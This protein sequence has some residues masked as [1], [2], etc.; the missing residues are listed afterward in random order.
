MVTA[1]PRVIAV[2]ALVLLIA[3]CT[4]P[5]G[6][7]T[8]GQGTQPGSTTSAAAKKRVAV[9]IRGNPTTLNAAINSAGPGGVAG[10]SEVEVMVHAGLGDVDLRRVVGPRLAERLPSV[11][12]GQWKLLPDGRMETSWTIRSDAVWHDGTPLTT[13]DLLF[14]AQLGQDRE[15]GVL[16]HAG[17]NSVDQIDAVDARTVRVTWKRPYINADSMFSGDFA[18]PQPEHILAGPYR[19]DPV[20]FLALPYW[21]RSFVGTGPFKVREWVDNSHAILEANERYV[22]GRPKLDEVE[23]RFILDP[24]VIVANVLAGAVEVT[25]GRGLSFEQASQAASQWGQ[26][27]MDLSFAA[28]SWIALFPQFVNP[29]PAVIADVRFRRALL[30][31]IDRQGLVDTFQ[32]GLIPVADSYVSPSQP[33]HKDVAAGVVR[34]AYDPQRAAQLIEELGYVRGADGFYRERANPT[35]AAPRVEVRT[36]SGDDLRDKVLYATADAWQKAGVATETLVIPRQRADD[37]EYRATRPAFEIVR[38]PNDLS[39]SAL[40]RLHSSEA[41][42][43]ENQFRRSNRVRYMN[44]ELDAL[45]DR[46]LVTIPLAE[47]MQVGQQIVHHVSDQLPIMGLLY[48]TEPMLIGSRLKNVDANLSTRNAHEWDAT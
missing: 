22:L 4:G 15:L 25:M 28:A 20:G 23:V 35:G 37:R 29:D 27:R 30:H 17:F 33:E 46:Y 21:T 2:L 47:R 8:G 1:P 45:I 42:L 13:S 19:E 18:V 34:Y 31:L 41:A 26:G 40:M 10:V 5:T 14:A 11:D 7:P 44:G 9:A 48:N 3:G 38:Q 39:E 6:Q 16:N 24:N 12:N 43:P 32:G 36:T